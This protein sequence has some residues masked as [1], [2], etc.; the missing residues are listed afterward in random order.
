MNLTLNRV[1]RLARSAARTV[2]APARSTAPPR[3]GRRT[4]G[5]PPVA[6]HGV[7]VEYDVVRLGLPRLAY[8]PERDGEPD[9]GEVVW[10]WVSYEDD[11]SRGKDRP[12]LVIAR[13]G[14][15]LVVLQLTSKDKDLDRA[16]EARHGR[17][18]LDIGS[19]AW[20]SR[21]RPSE[22]RLDRLLWASAG[23]VRREGAA[24]DRGRYDAVV[25]ALR[26]LHGGR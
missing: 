25:G 12:V 7:T 15:R 19:G 5:Q 4:G 13:E 3:P 20:D 11:P 21:G 24:L 9:P 8:S 6:A 14:D 10:T 18:W 26:A 1:L 23:D 2:L 22:V 17:S 16:A